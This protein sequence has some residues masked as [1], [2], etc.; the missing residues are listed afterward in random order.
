MAAG[1]RNA[2]EALG[3]APHV[4]T[5][6]GFLF[7]GA[8]GYAAVVGSLFAVQ[9]QL[10]YHPDP[11]SPEPGAFGAADMDVVDVS[12][13]D[14]LTVRSWYRPPASPD[15][16]VL[17]YFHGNAG[18]LGL[19]AG[20]IR[21]YLEAG[22]GV[23][24]AGYRGYGGNPGRPSEEGLYA[25]ARAALRFLAGQGIEPERVV[26]YGESLGSGVA[27]HLAF[28]TRVRAVVLEA[29]FSSIP[30]IAA[31]RFPFA[32]VDW[33][34]LDRFDSRSK[35]ARIGVPVLFL[36]GERDMVVPIESAERL[37]EA[38]ASPKQFARFPRADHN[39]LYDH[40][41]TVAVLRFFAD[42]L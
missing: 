30:D 41:A 3:P 32:P 4:I 31:R 17:L 10:M 40:G 6:V 5:M 15:H 16:P 33:L 34:V 38:A 35:I 23:L 21:P 19:R 12:T 42:H 14:G 27:V 36:H 25:D 39:D 9:R 18:H 1:R 26:L 11:E 7:L 8:A 37:F 2:L 13:A 29:P 22:L 28:E 20:K 24:L